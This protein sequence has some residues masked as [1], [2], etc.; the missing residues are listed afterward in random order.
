MALNIPGFVGAETSWVMKGCIQAPLKEGGQD[1]T[2]VPSEGTT[3]LLPPSS[4]D[5]PRKATTRTPEPETAATPVPCP[6]LLG[7]TSPACPGSVWEGA[8]GADSVAPPAGL[9]RGAV[10]APSVPW[11]GEA[12]PLPG[13][14][15]RAGKSNIDFRSGQTPSVPARGEG[16]PVLDGLGET[17]TVQPGGWEAKKCP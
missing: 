17:H 6:D 15:G 14:C 12:Q 11:W 2:P 13:P 10:K 16:Q 1:R 3:Q 8:M 5:T 9:A 7:R 4:K